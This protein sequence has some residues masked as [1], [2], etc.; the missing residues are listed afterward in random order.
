V[1]LREDNMNVYTP[2][3]EGKIRGGL[4]TNEAGADIRRLFNASKPLKI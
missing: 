4:L 1:I 2:E 3:V